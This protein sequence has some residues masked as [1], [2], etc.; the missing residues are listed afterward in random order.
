MKTVCV[1]DTLTYKHAAVHMPSQLIQVVYIG[2]KMEMLVLDFFFFSFSCRFVIRSVC[3]L[4]AQ[5]CVVNGVF[6]SGVGMKFHLRVLEIDFLQFYF[7]IFLSF[8]KKNECAVS[9][10]DWC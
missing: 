5:F 10:G 2:L 6:F 9:S 1:A 8:L 4:C 3:Q 7:I